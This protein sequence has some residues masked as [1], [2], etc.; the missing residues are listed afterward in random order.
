MKQYWQEIYLVSETQNTE[1][2]INLMK[3]AHMS[4]GI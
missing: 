4:I 1:I 3:S 2:E